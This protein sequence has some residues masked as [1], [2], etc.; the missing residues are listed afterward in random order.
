MS[1]PFIEAR[2][3]VFQIQQEAD[4]LGVV[5]KYAPIFLLLGFAAKEVAE[6]VQEQELYGSKDYSKTNVAGEFDDILVLLF[7]WLEV[8]APQV[9]MLQTANSVNGYGK[10]SNALEQL[11]PVIMDLMDDPHKAAPE[12]MRR[13]ISIGKHLPTPY[14][15]LE[16]MQATIAKVFANRPVELYSVYCPILGRE[17]DE[18]ES[19]LKYGHLERLMRIL[20]NKVKRTL[21]KS[22]W[23][24]YYKELVDWQNSAKNLQILKAKLAQQSGVTVF[25]GSVENAKRN[26]EPVAVY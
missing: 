26:L 15:E 2:T 22:D 23:L 8:Y 21:R 24:P 6:L 9:D 16:H 1:H 5:Y 12:C 13:L 4:L 7:S 20:R 14:V 25:Q 10:H 19:L 11:V 3:K 18:A 17:L